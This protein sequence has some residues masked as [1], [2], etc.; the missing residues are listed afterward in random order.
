MTRAARLTVPT[1]EVRIYGNSAP[2]RDT[3]LPI[4]SLPG[5]IRDTIAAHSNNFTSEFMT[6]HNR[7]AGQGRIAINDVKIS[8]TDTT[9]FHPDDQ[10]IGLWIWIWSTANPN[11]ARTSDDHCA[12]KSPLYSLA[13]G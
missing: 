2:D 11:V 3:G 8:A 10:L 5:A 7:I 12:H 1:I 4:A 6:G 9:G 13:K